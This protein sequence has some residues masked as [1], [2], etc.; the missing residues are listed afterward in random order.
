MNHRGLIEQALAEDIGARDITS[1]TVIPQDKTVT[2]IIQ[3]RQTGIIAGLEIARQTFAAVDAALVFTSLVQDGDEV[4]AGAGLA[5]IHGS[6]K[7]ILKAE[8]TALNFMQILSGMATTTHQ[9]VKAIAHTK[10]KIKDTRKTIPLWR[11]ISKQAV[12]LGGGVN[13]RMRLDDGILI[14]DNHLAIAGGDITTAVTL[15]KQAHPGMV[16]VECDTLAQVE[17]ALSAGAD[18]ILLDNM[19]LPELAAAVRMVDKRVP[20]EASGGIDL[21]SVARVAE[22]GVDFIS[23]SK[24]TM[25]AGI[26]DIGLDWCEAP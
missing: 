5:R 19:T 6:A 22:T 13:H 17:K 9:Y 24:I 20:L 10:A 23:T 14:K 16:M 26:M 7:G 21:K 15:A 8:R 3:T 11:D 12:A 2:H 18:Y 1:N 25:G 4:T